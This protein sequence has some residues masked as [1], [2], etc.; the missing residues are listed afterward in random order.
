MATTENRLLSA[1]SFQPSCFFVFFFLFLT[2]RTCP[3]WFTSILLMGLIYG[4]FYF[5]NAI[6]T[7]PGG[8]QSSCW[9][10]AD[11]TRRL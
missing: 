8:F 2:G 11:G 1:H 6:I 5:A 9:W 4:G 10:N 7:Q 3:A